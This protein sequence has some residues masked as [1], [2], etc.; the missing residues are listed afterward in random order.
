MKNV[1]RSNTRTVWQLLLLFP[2]HHAS[3]I[4]W[5]L[6]CT[7][8]T[9]C[10]CL[11]VGIASAQT[12]D[13]GTRNSLIMA[14]A[15]KQTAAEYRALSHQAYNVARMRLEKALTTRTSSDKNLAVVMDI[16]DTLLNT[17]NYWGYLINTG[18]DFFDDSIWDQ[19]IQENKVVPMPGSVDFLAFC[20]TSNVEVFYV[21]ARNQGSKTYEYA[22]AHLRINGFPYADENHLTVLTDTSD[23]QKRHDE[24]RND[25]DIVIYMGDNL[26]DFKR[27]YYVTDVE[28][29]AKLMEQ[30]KDLFGRE[31]ILLP[32]PTDGHWVRAIF[33][34]S[35]PSPT[36]ANR[37]ILRKAATSV[38]SRQ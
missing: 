8:S 16:D 31:F 14:V 27:A 17:T 7:A 2:K 29:R 35:E 28:E 23:K 11:L 1:H 38:K 6:A 26:N 33:G 13:H 4:R 20:K 10:L 32:N 22:L 21:T 25:Y 37:E 15:W 9:V 34:E 5:Q 12:S 36:D 19:W 18:K 30:D 24:I 3:S